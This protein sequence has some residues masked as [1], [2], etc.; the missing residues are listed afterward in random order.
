[1]KTQKHHFTAK[2]PYSQSYGF[3]SGHVQ[4]SELDHREGWALK[5]LC[6]WTMVLEK[7]L[8][9]P[10]DCKKIKPVHPMEINPE[11]SLEVLLMKLKLQYFGHLMWRADSLEKILNL[12]KIEGSRRWRWQRMR[13]M[14]NT[15]NSM[16]MNLG[17]LWKIEKDR[18]AWHA[19]IYW[20]TKHQTLLSNWTT[21]VVG[22]YLRDCL[23]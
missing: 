1:M 14:G 21:F 5:N 8:E 20:V 19:V 23:S 18:E 17:K 11:Y 9:S 3:S 13:W 16:D 6:F 22:F 15:T 4:M 12:G 7:T 10:S 2:G